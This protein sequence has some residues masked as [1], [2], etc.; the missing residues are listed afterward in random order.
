VKRED[1]ESKEELEEL[2]AMT[3]IG[4]CHSFL[5]SSGASGGKVESESTEDTLDGRL[6]AG[7][8]RFSRNA[9]ECKKLFG[10]EGSDIE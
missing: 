5:L 8:P 1:A 2:R 10:S 3:N 7:R 4:K 6:L 9:E